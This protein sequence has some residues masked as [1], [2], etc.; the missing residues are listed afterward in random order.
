[1]G[2]AVRKTWGPGGQRC[3]LTHRLATSL[4]PSPLQRVKPA[5]LVGGSLPTEHR[6]QAGVR[7]GLQALQANRLLPAVGA[8]LCRGKCTETHTWAH[9]PGPEPPSGERRPAG[10]PR[11]SLTHPGAPSAGRAHRPRGGR[12]V[13]GP[14]SDDGREAL[15]SVFTAPVPGGRRR[16]GGKSVTSFASSN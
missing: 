11:V 13:R 1:M 4:G 2:A 12:R 7:G 15:S 3:P 14:Q 8:G 16:S 9:V 6:P 10:S 5:T